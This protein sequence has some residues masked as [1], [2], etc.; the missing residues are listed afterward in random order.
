MTSTIN[1]TVIVYMVFFDTT[2]NGILWYFMVFFAL[3]VLN[4]GKSS[5]WLF[6]HF[7]NADKDHGHLI[8]IKH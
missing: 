5:C 7:Y 2:K 1:Y 3:L 4:Y 8:H 6:G